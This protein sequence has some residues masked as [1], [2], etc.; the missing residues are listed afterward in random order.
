MC[1]LKFCRVFLKARIIESRKDKTQNFEHEKRRGR[2]KNSW[3]TVSRETLEAW[4][5]VRKWRR[6]AYEQML[7]Y[8]RSKDYSK[9]VI[10]AVSI[11]P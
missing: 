6:L 5:A 9:P 1:I 3:T 4:P 8:T 11:Y 7:S 2:P 10:S